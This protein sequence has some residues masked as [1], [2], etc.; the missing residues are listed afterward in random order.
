MR[1]ATIAMRTRQVLERQ[2]VRRSPDRESYLVANR[3][4]VIA[5]VEDD[6]LADIVEQ[7]R[8]ENQP[9]DIVCLGRTAE[10]LTYESLVALK[11]NRKAEYNRRSTQASEAHRKYR[12]FAFLRHAWL[13]SACTP[14]IG[15]EDLARML[16]EVDW[17]A[18]PSGSWEAVRAYNAF[19]LTQT[20]IDKMRA[21]GDGAAAGLAEQ[22]HAF[23]AD[24]ALAADGKP[25][26]EWLLRMEHE[27]W[28]AYVRVE[29]FEVATAHDT[30]VLFDTGQHAENDKQHRSNLAGLHPCLVPFAELE[31]VSAD[32]NGEYEARGLAS[33]GDF[34]LQDDRYTR[35]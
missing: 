24:A 10:S 21:K 35:I 28:N 29:G 32:V 2:L 6:E 7:A 8:N 13:G 3:P 12:L 15:R 23:D 34:R 30:S 22:S 9:Y 19:R 16:D 25:S 27:R 14:V 18:V 31:Q 4:L 33:L 1:N 20:E 5:V 17:T 11:G 26:R